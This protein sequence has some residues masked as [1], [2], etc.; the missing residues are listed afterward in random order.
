[1]NIQSAQ[2]IADED[3]NN[4][5]IKVVDDEGVERSAPVN[6]V[7][8]INTDLGK[9]LAKPGNAIEAAD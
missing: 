2:Y 9:W 5:A 1:M 3:G 8:W 4:V 7:T 6:G